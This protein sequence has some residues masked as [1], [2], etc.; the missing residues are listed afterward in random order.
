MTSPHMKI[1]P[2][3]LCALAITAASADTLPD[4]WDQLSDDDLPPVDLPQVAAVTVAIPQAPAVSVETPAAPPPEVAIP[5]AVAVTVLPVDPRVAQWQAL[6]RQLDAFGFDRLTRK[7][8]TAEVSIDNPDFAR[9]LEVLAQY[10]AL[11][12]PSDPPPPLPAFRAVAE[13][14]YPVDEAIY[15][16]N[17]QFY[18]DN[19]YNAVLVAFGWDD[20]ERIYDYIQIARQYGFKIILAYSGPGERT[21]PVFRSPAWLAQRLA[22]YGRFADALVLHWRRS[23][24][25]LLTPPKGWTRFL[26]DNARAMNPTLPVIGSVYYGETGDAYPG[27]EWSA[28]VP[29]DASGAIFQGGGTTTYPGEDALEQLRRFTGKP[30]VAVV[31]GD[32]AYYLHQFFNDKTFQQNFNIKQQVLADYLDAGFAAVITRHGDNDD[33]TD[34]IGQTPAR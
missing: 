16:E 13:V 14:H 5:A 10:A 19:G 22:Y 18:R 21:R 31:L 25:H 24:L 26:A 34:N 33:R 12:E 32:R 7:E 23:S 2:A 20:A 3:I 1:F 8:S 27:Y 9:W 6:Y 28:S 30:A 17:L 11:P 15:R 29:A 4:G